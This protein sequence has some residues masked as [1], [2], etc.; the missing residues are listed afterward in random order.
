MSR[1]QVVL[2]CSLQTLVLDS[3]ILPEHSIKLK[4]GPVSRLVYP[5]EKKQTNRIYMSAYV[6]LNKLMSL[7]KKIKFAA[8]LSSLSQPS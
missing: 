1:S 2:N 6:L 8:L 5:S 7:K 4:L 3:V